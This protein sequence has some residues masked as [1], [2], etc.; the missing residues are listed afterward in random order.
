MASPLLTKE[1]HDRIPTASWL[2]LIDVIDL[3]FI[4]YAIQFTCNA[5]LIF[6]RESLIEWVEASIEYPWPETV[7]I[8]QLLIG[9]ETL[10]VPWF[11]FNDA[12]HDGLLPLDLLKQSAPN[13]RLE[14]VEMRQQITL[15]ELLERWEPSGDDGGI[16][17]LGSKVSNQLL[18]SGGA[19]LQH[20]QMIGSL[21]DDKSSQPDEDDDKLN[22]LESLL[23]DN[24]LEKSTELDT[25]SGNTLWIRNEELLQISMLANDLQALSS[26]RDALLSERDSLHLQHSSLANDLQALSSERDALLSERDAFGQQRDELASKYSE[27]EKEFRTTQE[28]L[29]T[30]QSE[31]HAAIAGLDSI[32]AENA[33]LRSDADAFANTRL[34]LETELE[35]SRRALE[36]ANSL[37]ARLHTSLEAIFPIEQYKEAAP[38]LQDADDQTLIHHYTIQGQSEGR[39]PSYAELSERYQSSREA[40][41]D[42][43]SKLINLEQLF[44]HFTSQLELLKDLIYRP[45]VNQ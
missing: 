8:T 41:D 25:H 20:A 21:G 37:N 26:E 35:T 43:Q 19:N 17:L 30:I 1:F 9:E 44:E 33:R 5:L 22:E 23:K 18:I 7:Q 42:L 32:H 27:L 39:I 34:T 45:A 24:W 2:I 6:S 13:L 36:E 28:R 12:R 10:E 14:S 4:K 15:G 29:E 31:H 38:D 40:K 11:H 3:D 16:L